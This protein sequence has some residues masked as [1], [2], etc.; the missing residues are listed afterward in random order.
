MEEKDQNFDFNCCIDF[1][2]SKTTIVVSN[3]G[4]ILGGNTLN[5][6]FGLLEE[7]FKWKEPKLGY[8]D[9]EHHITHIEQTY[10]EH[11]EVF[12]SFLGILFDAIFVAMMDI[13]KQLFL[14][15]IFMSG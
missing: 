13:T 4:E 5:F 11:K 15:N 12:D 6:G 3:R 2:A 1:G 9:I 14:K 10:E 7:T 8:L